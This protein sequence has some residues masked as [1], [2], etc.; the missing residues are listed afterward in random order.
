MQVIASPF[1]NAEA[2]RLPTATRYLPGSGAVDYTSS[3]GTIPTTINPFTTGSP[4]ASP[5]STTA[6]PSTSQLF[7]SIRE[8][9]STL[10]SSSSAL[11]AAAPSVPSGAPAAGLT[12]QS[13]TQLAT[14]LNAQLNPEGDPEIA[15]FIQLGAQDPDVAELMIE[16]ANNG[17]TVEFGDIP[18]VPSS[19]PGEP[20]LQVNGFFQPDGEGSGFIRINSSLRGSPE[21]FS[22]FLHESLHAG[23]IANGN[24][25][26]EEGAAETFSAVKSAQLLGEQP[27]DAADIFQRTR[28]LYDQQQPELPDGNGIFATLQEIGV[29][30][31]A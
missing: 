8:L 4:N 21:A 26:D 3:V 23:T 14:Q 30:F 16:A 29:N 2:L 10:A 22:T 27:P 11:A 28:Q 13:S 15:R 12:G 20:P 5:L 7:S 25:L 6:L 1:L 17:V 18:P 19:V 24:S 31:F 9:I